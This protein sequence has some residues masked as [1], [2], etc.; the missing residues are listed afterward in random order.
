[1]LQ[2][3]GLAAPLAGWHPRII[4]KTEALVK[5]KQRSLVGLDA[6]VEAMLQRGALPAP[7]SEKWPNRC[8]THELQSE[9]MLHN[10]P[11][12]EKAIVDKLRD[13]GL[14]AADDSARFNAN[15]NRGWQFLPLPVCRAAWERRMGGAWHWTFPCEAWASPSECSRPGLRR[16]LCL[17]ASGG[18]FKSCGVL[19]AIIT[20]N[21]DANC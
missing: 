5:Q 7:L 21:K 13:V 8:F 4:Y 17:L 2:N 3:P 19:I 11:T 16:N 10:G 15:G 18:A 20:N 6:W 9:A 14:I 12:S 1:M